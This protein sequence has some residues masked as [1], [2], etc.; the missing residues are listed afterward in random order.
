MSARV[1]HP[2]NQQLRLALELF[3]SWAEPS[4]HSKVVGLRNENKFKVVA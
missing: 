3:R 2:A 1:L 4:L